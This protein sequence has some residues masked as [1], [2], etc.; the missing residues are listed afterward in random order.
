MEK[1]IK[2]FWALL[3]LAALFYYPQIG[4][5][6]KEGAFAWSGVLTG[7]ALIAASFFIPFPTGAITFIPGVLLAGG[8]LPFALIPSSGF[9][10]PIWAYAAGA[11]VLILIFRKK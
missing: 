5:D 4:S 6:K 8:S 2:I 10:I 7:G 11:M 3:I 1:K 9:S